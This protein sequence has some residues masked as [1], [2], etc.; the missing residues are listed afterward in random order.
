MRIKNFLKELFIKRI[1]YNMQPYDQN[2]DT[3][4]SRNLNWFKLI[5]EPHLSEVLKNHKI[6]SSLDLGCGNGRMFKYLLKYSDLVTGIDKIENININFL[7]ENTAF[8][9]VDIFNY[10]SQ[11]DLVFLFGMIGVLTKNYDKSKIQRKI[12]EILK[13]NGLIVSIHD[14]NF[15]NNFLLGLN[16][17]TIKEI[18]VDN[19]TILLILKKY[20]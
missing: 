4:G 19:K 16:F 18:E 6:R 3:T 5:V 9:K 20:S 17:K 10:Y 7:K 15:K 1:K 13:P 14:K 8:H 2:G 11:H 12:K